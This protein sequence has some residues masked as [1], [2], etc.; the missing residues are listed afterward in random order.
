VFP[1]AHGHVETCK[2]NVLKLPWYPGEGEALQVFARVQRQ[3]QI[4]K[5]RHTFVQMED[6]LRD[7]VFERV[8]GALE[9]LSIVR[10]DILAKTN[11]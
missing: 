9:A 5:L 1:N 4:R 3:H 11:L 7:A 6:S 8:K 2:A 10:D